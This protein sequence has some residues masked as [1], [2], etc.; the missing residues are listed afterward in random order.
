M[1]SIAELLTAVL[2]LYGNAQ[3]INI[4]WDEEPNKQARDGATVEDKGYP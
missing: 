2:K 1:S 3:E 4:I